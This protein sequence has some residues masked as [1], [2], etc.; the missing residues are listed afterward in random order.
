MQD[1]H[2]QSRRRSYDQK[3]ITAETNEK[4]APSQASNPASFGGTTDI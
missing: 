2:E 3:A 1:M 4:A